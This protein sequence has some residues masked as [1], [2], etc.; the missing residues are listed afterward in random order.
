MCKNVVVR[1]SDHRPASATKD[2]K[3]DLPLVWQ[4]IFRLSVHG[5]QMF[6]AVGQSLGFVRRL[7][8]VLCESD[9]LLEAC[10][11]H[12][13]VETLQIRLINTVK[14]LS[15]SLPTIATSPKAPQSHPN[16]R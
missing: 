2:H 3:H 4:N 10:D 7:V 15:D 5:L 6:K 9:G 12:S 1:V 16:N 13:D 11:A 14:H 8:K